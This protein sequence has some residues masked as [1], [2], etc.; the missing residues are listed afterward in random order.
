MPTNVRRLII[1]ACVLVT[2]GITGVRAQSSL[3]TAQSF[4]VLAGST[5]TN[6]GASVITGDLGVHPGAAVTGFP[7]GI[8]T[9]TIHAGNATAL[10]AKN[11]LVTQYD[12][13]TAAAC[14]SDLTGQDLGGQTLT[15]G[16]YC[17]NTSAQL[18][19]TLTL[20]A[21]GNPAATFVF[22]TGSTLTTA[23]A[24][25][26]LLINGGNPCG[27]AW[28]VGSSAILGS[29]TSFI[30]NLIALTSITLNTNANIVG[31]RALARNGAVTL[32]D[33]DISFASCGVA[34]PPVPTL[35]QWATIGLAAL[36]C[37]TAIIA[38]RQRRKVA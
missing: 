19:G 13:L 23:N 27:V 12:A 33:N 29:T 36:L 21:Q 32:D 3:G 28:R 24:A 9:G 18:T 35:S 7:P 31:G 11:D 15:P 6:T 1:A 22:K 34:P 17:F 16:V 26:V 30:G 5:V 25:S 14:S 20:N 8:V 10:Q 38:L 2:C 37:L 4:A